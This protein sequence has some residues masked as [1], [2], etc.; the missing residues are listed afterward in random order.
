MKLSIITINLNDKVG[1][2]QTIDSVAMQTFTDYEFIIIDGKSSDG[3]IEVINSNSHKITH[4]LSETDTGIYNA[5]NKGIQLAKGEY[6]YFLN[7]GDRIFSDNV[8][9]RVFEEDTTASFICGNFFTENNDIVTL[10][11]PYRDR[12]WTFA[13]YDIYSTYLCHQAFFIRKDNFDKYGMYSED[14]RITADW[15]LFLIAIGANHESVLYKDIDLVIYNLEGMSSTIGGKAIYE[16]K[17]KVA[18]RRFST[19]L[20]RQLHR[21]YFLEQNGYITDAVK[22]SATLSFLIRVYYKLKR[23][24]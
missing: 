6:L 16:E 15:E 13:L 10:E 20:A 9:Q 4:A 18:K 12:D 21:L 17:Q 8:L 5:M 1:L 2:Q 14:L 11:T 24:F 23:I 22:Q 7:A 19:T 3:S